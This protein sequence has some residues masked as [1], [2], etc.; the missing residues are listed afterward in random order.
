M[1]DLSSLKNNIETL[2]FDRNSSF[3]HNIIQSLAESLDFSFEGE[4]IE[5]EAYDGPPVVFMLL[6]KSM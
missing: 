4:W 6:I 2:V 5:A 3:F 1:T